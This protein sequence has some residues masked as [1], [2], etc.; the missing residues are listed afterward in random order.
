M[1]SPLLMS[2]ENSALVVIDV[3]EKLIPA[4]SGSK[5]IVWNIQRLARAANLLNVP[6]RVTE[7][8]PKGLGP[9][10]QSLK[11]GL[12]DPVEKLM[13]SCRECQTMLDDLRGQGI[14]NLTLVGIESHVCVLQTALDF[15]TD[16]F[17]VYIV[18]DAVGAR[19]ELDHEIA[20][21][22]A[23]TSGCFITTTEAVLFEWCES[24]SAPEFKFDQQNRSGTV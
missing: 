1:R 14:T 23:E 6:A 3:Q 22:R 15:I 19:S 8:Y 4:I 13:F 21:R 7:Q 9:T 11:E 16:G 2:R 10:V 24:A 12:G 17:N 18:A 20:L 5:K